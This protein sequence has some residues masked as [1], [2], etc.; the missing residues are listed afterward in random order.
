MPSVAKCKFHSRV[1]RA[2][3][4]ISVVNNINTTRLNKWLIIIAFRNAKANTFY[5]WEIKALNLLIYILY[6]LNQHIE[7]TTLY[8]HLKLANQYTHCNY[9]VY[10]DW[11][12]FLLQCVYWLV[13]ILTTMCILIGFHWKPINI[14]IVVR[15]KTNQYTHCSK[16]EN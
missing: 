4:F 7:R 11:F 8:H 15:M 10:I 6:N 1:Y 14:H 9:N 3:S 16:N 12:S 13:F 5:L 2:E